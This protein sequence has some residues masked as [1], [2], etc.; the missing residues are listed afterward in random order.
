MK[1]KLFVA[2]TEPV[3]PLLPA[4]EA[5]DPAAMVIGKGKGS[6]KKSRIFI[7]KGILPYGV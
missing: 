3:F 7:R 5:I 1:V 6:G 4:G 2:G